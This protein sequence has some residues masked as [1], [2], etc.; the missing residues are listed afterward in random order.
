MLRDGAWKTGDLVTQLGERTPARREQL[1]VGVGKQQQLLA[2][3]LRVPA[4]RHLREP[5]ELRVREA[6]RLAD[7]ADRTTR[8]IRRERRD[9][10]RV[11]PSVAFGDGQDQLLPDVAR[12]VEGD[13]GDRA[14]L[15]A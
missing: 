12:E 1:A 15:A 7:V 8:A 5:L 6:E 10:R 11:F 3:A 13:V 14:E 4:L 9:E 2:D